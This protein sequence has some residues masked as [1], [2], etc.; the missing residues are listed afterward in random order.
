MIQ[1]IDA[2]FVRRVLPTRPLDAHKGTFGKLLLAVGSAY[3]PGAACMATLAALRTGVGIAT[4]AAP[5]TVAHGCIGRLVEPTW[6][7]LPENADG[8]VLPEAVEKIAEKLPGYQAVLAGCG[9]SNEPDAEGFVC[10]LLSL[11]ALAG[12]PL[13]LD[14]DGIN[15]AARHIDLLER[16]PARLIL[17]PHRMEMARLCGCPIGEVSGE[18]AAA[19]AAQLRATVV[20]KSEATLVARA[21][22]R[23]FRLENAANPGLAKGGSGDVLAGIVGSLCAQG[24]SP[25]DAACAG[26]WLHSQAGF[27]ALRRSGSVSMLPGDL[28]G[29]LPEVFLN[30]QGAE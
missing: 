19:L 16:C 18:K 20:L 7:P 25:D 26:V 29:L 11:P 1:P 5:R 9:L 3:Y 4:V 15:C 22:G 24:V 21:D 28:P 2:A 6:L 17:T 30:L 13:V 27:A 12:K 14:A 10:A 8:V 23:L